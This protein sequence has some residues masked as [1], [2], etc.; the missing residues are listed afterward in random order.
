MH[1]PYLPVPHARKCASLVH[2]KYHEPSLLKKTKEGESYE[3][4]L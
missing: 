2:I 1:G 4:G 3:L